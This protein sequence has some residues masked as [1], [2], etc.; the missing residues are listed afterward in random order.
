MKVFIMKSLTNISCTP[1]LRN[2]PK[3]QSLTV[4]SN[5]HNKLYNDKSLSKDVLI[6]ND[7]S[8]T[9][10]ES[11][12]KLVSEGNLN[13]RDAF[14][15]LTKSLSLIPINDLS[16][17]CNKMK[18]VVSKDWVGTEDD[19]SDFI[20]D[21]AIKRKLDYYELIYLSALTSLHNKN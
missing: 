8:S 15:I 16:L 10:D 18:S 19:L 17:L 21:T 7:N 9:L 14:N 3:A 4:S 12:F 5:T 11:Q 1:K 6:S 13:A 20:I 2:I